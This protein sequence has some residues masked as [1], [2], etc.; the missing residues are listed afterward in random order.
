MRSRSGF[1]GPLNKVK[2]PNTAAVCRRSWSGRKPS[3]DLVEI[4]H[5]QL[6][7]DCSCEERN[8]QPCDASQ[9]A[10]QHHALFLLHR[11]AL[12]QVAVMEFL[13]S[14]G[15]PK[16]GHPLLIGAG[17]RG[18]CGLHVKACNHAA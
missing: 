6:R 13:H 1:A 8:S 3:L 16:L 5:K 12:Q 9:K 7:W 15:H 10:T 2:K 11:A 4:V 14:S 18:F 17:T